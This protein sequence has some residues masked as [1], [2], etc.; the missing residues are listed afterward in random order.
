SC[1]PAHVA[2]MRQAAFITTPAKEISLLG[3]GGEVMC[4]HDGRSAALRTVSHMEQLPDTPSHWIDVVRLG[5]NEM[6][7]LRRTVGAD[8]LAALVPAELFVPKVSS[9]GGPFVAHASA[10]TRLGT[11]IGEAGSS[12][13][14]F[15]GQALTA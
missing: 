7:R 13:V 2:M 10:A 9:Q 1:S 11:V 14:K 3:P 8:A 12:S 15:D 5:S 6:V 4:T